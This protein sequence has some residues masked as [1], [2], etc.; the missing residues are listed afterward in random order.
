MATSVTVEPVACTA[1]SM[2]FFDRLYDN[3]VVRE[4]GEIVKCFD[5]F[6]EDFIVS[7]ELRKVGGCFRAIRY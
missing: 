4:S 5:E 1:M 2:S 6:H 7:D 3:A